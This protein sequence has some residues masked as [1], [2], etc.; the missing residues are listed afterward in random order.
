MRS[1]ANSLRFA[2]FSMERSFPWVLQS[3]WE[4]CYRLW[5][6]HRY[7]E[8]TSLYIDWNV[9]HVS[10]LQPLWPLRKWC[11]CTIAI[12][13][14]M[15][16]QYLYIFSVVH[17]KNESFIDHN[18]M[19]KSSTYLLYNNDT[20]PFD[21]TKSFKLQNVRLPCLFEV[22]AYLYRKLHLYGEFQFETES[23]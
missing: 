11:V 13:S 10:S 7:P 3:A 17:D 19:A 21:H 15:F 18:W 2:W 8:S 22:L 14:T 23:L 16:G 6:I 12:T 1:L 5:N 4:P 9:S 20:N